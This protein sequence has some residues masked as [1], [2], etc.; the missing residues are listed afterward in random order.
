MCEAL[1][2]FH[3]EIPQVFSVTAFLAAYEK[4]EKWHKKLL[5]YTEEN[6]NYLHQWF[7]NHLPRII[8]NEVQGT[9]L[10]WINFKALK[11]NDRDLKEMIFNKAKVALE[12]GTNFGS[13]GEGFMRLNFACSRTQLLESLK[14]I[15]KAV[16]F[17]ENL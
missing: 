2:R 10:S 3:L 12:P 11:K 8:P 7:Q 4:G 1:S 13:G 15:E 9:Y 17:E 5:E 16:H 14:R 6:R